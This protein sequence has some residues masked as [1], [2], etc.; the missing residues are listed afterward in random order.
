MENIKNTYVTSDGK[1]AIEEYNKKNEKK[2]KNYNKKYR[3][4]GEAEFNV[5]VVK[6]KVGAEYEHSTE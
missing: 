4:F 2:N 5:G 6:A 3:V 1:V